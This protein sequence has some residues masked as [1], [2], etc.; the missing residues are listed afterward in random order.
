MPRAFFKILV[1]NSSSTTSDTQVNIGMLL[2]IVITQVNI[3]M[4]LEIVILNY[5][6]LF[7]TVVGKWAFV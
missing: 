3:G 2:E 1:S 4:F 7:P 5:Y 6:F